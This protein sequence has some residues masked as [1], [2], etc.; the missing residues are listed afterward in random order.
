MFGGSAE[1]CSGGGGRS[2]GGNVGMPDPADMCVPCPLSHTG[3][4]DMCGDDRA[5]PPAKLVLK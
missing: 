3:T 4:P 1:M 5:T 2:D